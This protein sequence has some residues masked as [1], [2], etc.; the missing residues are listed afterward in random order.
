[1]ADTLS[2][3]RWSLDDLLPEPIDQSIAAALADLD[4]AATAFEAQR[5]RLTDA[6]SPDEFLA[7]LRQYE[8]M[9][10]RAQRLY[11]YGLSLIHI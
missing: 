10:D 8:A 4:A 7:I 9:V 6:L 11:A 1:M 3:Q 2:P 5:E